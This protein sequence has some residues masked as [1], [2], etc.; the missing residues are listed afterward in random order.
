LK[1]FETCEINEEEELDEGE[2]FLEGDETEGRFGGI[3]E[4][5]RKRIVDKAGGE[6]EEEEG[7][8]E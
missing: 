6:G 4:G 1:T 8:E 5:E 2:N 7:E 3:S